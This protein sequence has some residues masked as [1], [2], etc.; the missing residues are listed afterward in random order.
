[1][2]ALF[3]NYLSSTGELESEISAV[4]VRA[5]KTFTAYIEPHLGAQHDAR[6]LDLGCGFGRNVLAAR[7]R[8]FGNISGIDISP[9]QVTFGRSTLGLDNI[10]VADALAHLAHAEAAFD[11]ILLIDVLEHCDTVYAVELLSA[12]RRALVPGGRLLVQVPNGMT[13]LAPNYLGDVTHVRPYSSSSLAQILR[14]GG[15]RKFLLNE[16][17]PI[18]VG[19]RGIVRNL[20]WRLLLKPMIRA[21][22]L[23]ATGSEQGRIYTPNLMAV[24]IK[25]E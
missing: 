5:Q 17:P 4:I 19:A 3:A 2:S 8:G 7:R 23:A 16:Q 24:A 13:P 18:A 14:M 1:M 25:A 21:Y 10:T 22:L 12:I 9:E 6:I 11:A 15:F 20:L